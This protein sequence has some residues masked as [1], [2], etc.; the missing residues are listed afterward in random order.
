VR[1]IILAKLEVIWLLAAKLADTSSQ[2]RQAYVAQVLLSRPDS[3][4]HQ[5]AGLV[6]RFTDASVSTFMLSGPTGIA[7]H[8]LSIHIEHERETHQR[9]SGVS[10]LSHKCG[11]VLG[12]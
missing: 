2:E 9:E 12:L 11:P 5:L 4:P 1:D 7:S 8:E 10:S 6:R 3:A